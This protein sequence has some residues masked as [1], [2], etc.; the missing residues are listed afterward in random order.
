MNGRILQFE[1]RRH[2]EAMRM[3]PWLVTDR[4]DDSE[5][6][7]LEPHV[8][9][10][11]DCRNE[12]AA[13]REMRMACQGEA[14]SAS[15]SGDEDAADVDRGWRR[16]RA[17]LQPPVSAFDPARRQRSPPSRRHPRWQRWVL[18]AQ[19]AVIAVLAVFLWR[20]PAPAQYR[21]LGAAP[22]ASAGNLVIVFDPRLDE[23]HLRSL[24]LA[25]QARIVDGPNDAGAYVLAVP[26]A[27]LPMVQDALRAAPGVTLVATLG[28]DQPQ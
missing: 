27:R 22:A 11:A 14:R 10:C 18:A 13:L 15:P 2:D 25:S 6:D 4:L 28:Q 16:M 1:G 7:W 9:G 19:A 17:R 5:R 20:G 12:L 3:L 8:A 23:S 24:L 26:G 21:T